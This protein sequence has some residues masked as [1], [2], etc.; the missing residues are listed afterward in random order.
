M[1][2]GF[3][4]F[5]AH[6]GLLSVLEDRGVTPCRVA[7][8]S[9]GALVAGAH[10]AGLSAGALVAE[11][12]SLERSHFWDPGPLFG[13]LQGGLLRGELFR[14][15]LERMLPVGSFERCRVPLAVSTFDVLSRT[16]HVIEEGA[17]GSAIVASCAVPG[18][19][20]P[21]RREGRW[22]LDGGIRDRPG[23]A[24]LPAGTRVLFHHLASRSPWRRQSEFVLPRREGLVSLVIEGLPRSGPSQLEAGREA[25][26]LARAAASRALSQPIVEDAVHVSA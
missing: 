7:G 14:E 9:A 21:V 1:S 17:L 11:L 19:F 18:L 5:F 26:R 15:R 23:L 20:R 4:G 16:T 25:L 6:A 13:V 22:L 8:S 24:G 3:F 12:V 10:A 2:S